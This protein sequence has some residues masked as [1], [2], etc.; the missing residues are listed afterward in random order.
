M[1]FDVILISYFVLIGIDAIKRLVSDGILPHRI[2]SL[3]KRQMTLHQNTAYV[4]SCYWKCTYRNPKNKRLCKG[5]TSSVRTG[6]LYERSKLSI[7]ELVIKLI[8]NRLKC[9][10]MSNFVFL[11]F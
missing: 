4:D 11:Y 2:C 1:L 6:T 8:R 9:N 10:L 5:P 3:C 7:P